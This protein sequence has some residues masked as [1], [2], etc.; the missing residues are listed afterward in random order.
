MILQEGE[1]SFMK[2][3]VFRRTFSL[4]LTL[5]VALGMTTTVFAGEAKSGDVVFFA[6]GEVYL[7]Y[8]EAYV[9]AYSE[10]DY[11]VT[12]D[13]VSSSNPNVATV[14]KK[15]GEYF[16]KGVALGKVTI[17]GNYTYRGQKGS[18]SVPLEVKKLP[19]LFSSLKVNGK[20]V[21]LSKHPFGMNKKTKATSVK[22]KAKLASGWKV[23]KVTA[24]AYKGVKDYKGTKVKVT[25]KMIKKGKKIKFAKKYKNLIVFVDLV[26]TSTG[27]R[28]RYSFQFYR[29]T[30]FA[31]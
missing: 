14:Y 1:E 9:G 31:K 25:K 17:T 23:K 29:K 3:N 8:T 16:V 6:D 24:R 20:K 22:I 5:L 2:R 4:L 11:D 10:G 28:S 19:V 30:P 13:S 7:G 27:E 26:N 18:L 15:D 12:L 21:S